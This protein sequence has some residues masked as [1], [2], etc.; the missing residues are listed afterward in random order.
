MWSKPMLRVEMYS[1]P[2]SF[3]CTEHRPGELG[4]VSHA[5]ASV[6]GTEMTLASDTAS[7]VIVGTTPKRGDNSWKRSASSCS[8]P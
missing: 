3:K 6:A 7:L 2:A 4:L 8:Q 5:D 1:T